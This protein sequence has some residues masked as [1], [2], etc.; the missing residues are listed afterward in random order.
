MIRAATVAANNA[1][2][3]ALILIPR[4]DLT[5]PWRL[6][7]TD[8]ASIPSL[9]KQTGPRKHLRPPKQSSRAPPGNK[10]SRR[11]ELLSLVPCSAKSFCNN[12]V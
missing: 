4:S 6:P 2:L 11:S 1:V 3:R 12:G 9:H 7:F 8:S 10:V 5:G